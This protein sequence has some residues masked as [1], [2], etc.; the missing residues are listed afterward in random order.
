MP[1]SQYADELG[2]AVRQTI[3]AHH[4]SPA[5][6]RQAEEP[7]DLWPPT[8][9]QLLRLA[10]SMDERRPKNTMDRL[11]EV[12][13]MRGLEP[14]GPISAVKASLVG[15]P[16]HEPGPGGLSARQ[17]VR[18]AAEFPD[19]PSSTPLYVVDPVKAVASQY[20]EALRD[21]AVEIAKQFQM[22]LRRGGALRFQMA[23]GTPDPR[24]VVLAYPGRQ[25]VDPGAS[26]RAIS[27]VDRDATG[28]VQVA[29]GR[30]I[31]PEFFDRVLLHE[32]RHTLEGG[33]LGATY[34]IGG[35]QDWQAPRS[36]VSP[37][38]KNY[39]SSTGE[40]AARFGDARAR[41]AR[42][43]GRLISDDD[44]AEHA[45]KMI[46]AN[47]HGLGGGFYAPERAFYQAA[48]EADSNIRAH[49]NR[50]LQG[51]LTVPAVV[52]AGASQ[53]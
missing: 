2:D 26:G 14:A 46:L 34:S 4:G 13:E 25:S 48:R 19:S 30:Q 29:A 40:E 45:A 20:P 32:L 42:H 5:A 49:Q 36:L 33:G 6:V 35:Y 9:E 31:S 51:L 1:V 21:E 50:I 23:L 27:G 44:E 12:L 24:A 28:L 41:Y 52:A 18:A 16:S 38:K 43:S 10:A 22:P 11:A 8:D 17:W 7:L 3:R 47:E 37:R 15:M 53:D 39:L